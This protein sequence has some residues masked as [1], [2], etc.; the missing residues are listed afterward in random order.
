[1]D[2][3]AALALY[4]ALIA[5]N[6]AVERKGDT[7]PYTS[8]NGHMFSAL[9][10]DGTVAMRLPEGDREAF[11]KKYRTTLAAHY[12]VVQPEYVVVPDALLGKTGELKPYFA[13]SYAYVAAMKPKAT[14]KGK[15]KTTTTSKSA[16]TNKRSRG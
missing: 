2:R 10:K 15:P 11:L 8:L 14:T 5:T 6:S 9:H 16:R 12:G 7:V 1:M 13:K 4:D 3:S